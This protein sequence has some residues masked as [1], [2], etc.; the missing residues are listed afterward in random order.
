MSLFRLDA[1]I[2][3]EQS[4]SRQVA[5]LVEKG[6]VRR[7]AD[8]VDGRA[9]ILVVTDAGNEVASTLRRRRNENMGRVIADWTESDRARFVA[10]LDRFVNGYERCRPDMLAGLQARLDPPN[11]AGDQGGSE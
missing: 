2:R 3:G 4:V 5:Q 1:S 7:E 11:A 6:F 10:L 9:S 8:P